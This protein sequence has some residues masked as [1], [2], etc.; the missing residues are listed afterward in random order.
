MTPT[1][2]PG[3]SK[4]ILIIDDEIAFCTVIRDILRASGYRVLIAHRASDAQ[5][6]L[7]NAT[8]DLII[9]DIMMPEMDGLT[10][11]RTIRSCPELAS[12]P[13]LVVSA[14]SRDEDF[15]QVR[16]AGADG[17]LTKP[18]TSQELLTHIRHHLTHAAEKGKKA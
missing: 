11:I 1:H 7:E 14:K 9:S 13:I 2:P 4:L 8:P 15:K 12:I 3:Q 6:H 10:L 16:E 5:Q 18:F 17:F